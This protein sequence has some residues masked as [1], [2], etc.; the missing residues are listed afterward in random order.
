MV[1]YVI[2]V[3]L[4]F[5]RSHFLHLITFIYTAPLISST[6]FSLQQQKQNMEE[7]LDFLIHFF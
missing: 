2:L 7:T 4:E 3:V 6:G 1:N 5:T